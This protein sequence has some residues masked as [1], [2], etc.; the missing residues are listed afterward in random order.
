MNSRCSYPA[1]QA[2]RKEYRLLRLL[3]STASTIWSCKGERLA[4]LIFHRVRA[5][6]DPLFPGEPDR[7]Q[8]A[9]AMEVVA[10]CFNCLPLDEA[11]QRIASGASLPKRAVAITFDDGY[12]DN[13]TEALPILRR[14]G[15]TATFFIASG[16]LD[17]GCMWNDEAV[18]S[19]R[20][21]AG[22]E[23][24]LRP[25][26]LEVRSVRTSAEKSA[27]ID[28]VKRRLKYQATAARRESLDILRDITG[29]PRLPRLMLS[30]VQVRKMHSLGMGIGGHTVNHP[31][32][33]C[34]DDDV[35]LR[36][37]GED[38]E[39]LAGIIGGLPSLFAYPN[40]KP[41]QDYLPHHASMVRAV[42][43]RGAFTTVWGVTSRGIDMFQ[44][45]R[46]SPWDRQPTRFALRL[47]H[48]YTRNR[49]RLA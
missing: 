17:G 26:G 35:A 31:I 36:E 2:N 45:P 38:R 29:R 11:L 34:L 42:G 37:I 12:A 39:R 15:L 32:L 19:L 18:E 7:A 41:G 43:Y 3:V 24:D 1:F 27:A 8:F 21:Y 48:S 47:A 40:G 49:F 20:A 5:Q 9:D 4:V 28:A 13:F 6:R 14:L 44:L 25:M 10:R 33:A 46:F 23:I 16:F 22:P 30:S